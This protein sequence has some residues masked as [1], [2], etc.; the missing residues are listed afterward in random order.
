MSTIQHINAYLEKLPAPLQLEVLHFI[1]YLAQKKSPVKRT[2]EQKRV[3][4]FIGLGDSNGA[5][6]Q[7]E[8]LRDF[9]HDE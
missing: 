5:V 4:H 8:N 1:E 2:K 9:A 6:N 3:F 7:I